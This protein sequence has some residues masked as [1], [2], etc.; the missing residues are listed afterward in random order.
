MIKRDNTTEL[1]EAATTDF[2]KGIEHLL[3]FLGP[4]SESGRFC[5]YVRSTPFLSALSV[6][7]PLGKDYQK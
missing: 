6:A 4:E 3:S 7:S 2:F 1:I 5:H